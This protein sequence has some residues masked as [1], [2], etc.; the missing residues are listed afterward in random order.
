LTKHLPYEYCNNLNG[1]ISYIDASLLS[2]FPEE[3]FEFT[4]VSG[5]MPVTG[6]LIPWGKCWFVPIA[7]LIDPDRMNKASRSGVEM[8]G[9]SYDRILI[10]F[11][12]WRYRGA[13]IDC[14]VPLKLHAKFEAGGPAAE[15]AGGVDFVELDIFIR[16]FFRNP[17]RPSV[18]V[19]VI[20][21]RE[22]EKKPV[23]GINGPGLEHIVHVQLAVD[24]I[25]DHDRIL[26]QKRVLH[27][28]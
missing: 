11:H 10:C 5:R 3:D 4:P 26:F 27:R 9:H 19:A 14:V 22:A 17:G 18:V 13:E 28:G 24:D 6:P 23:P 21:A 12:V 8:Q 1:C 16:E 20:T 15:T 25:L 2:G 7:S